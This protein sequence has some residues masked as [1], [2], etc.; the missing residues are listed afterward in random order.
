[1]VGRISID[2]D[3][4]QNVQSQVL[5]LADE[6]CDVVFVLSGAVTSRLGGIARA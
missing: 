1:M 6:G 4:L 3:A 5:S 2:E